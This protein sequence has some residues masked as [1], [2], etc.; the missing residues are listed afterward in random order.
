MSRQA[1][2][3]VGGRGGTEELESGGSAGVSQQGVSWNQVGQQGVCWDQLGQLGVSRNH[4][5]QERVQRNQVGQ[6]GSAASARRGRGVHVN[7][8]GLRP[9]RWVFFR[10]GGGGGL[11]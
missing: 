1:S 11:E 8:L 2:A 6:E 7:Q 4:L 9:Y 3:E 10:L 5:G